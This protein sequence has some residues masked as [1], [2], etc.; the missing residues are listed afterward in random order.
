[1]ISVD[2]S[3][4][5]SLHTQ[6]D[7]GRSR[8]S[9]LQAL[10]A[11]GMDRAQALLS[12]CEGYFVAESRADDVLSTLTH[13]VRDL[14][15]NTPG[16]KTGVGVRL[17]AGDHAAVPLVN[18]QGRPIHANADRGSFEMALFTLGLEPIADFGQKHGH[19]YFFA[20]RSRKGSSTSPHEATTNRRMG[21]QLDHPPAPY[22]SASPLQTSSVI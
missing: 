14:D 18:T 4:Q 3:D 13:R 16:Q 5:I 21:A 22:C 17:I 12:L 7:I 9:D 10:L 6:R 11:E 1:M 2:A 20:M 19:N 8:A 15:P